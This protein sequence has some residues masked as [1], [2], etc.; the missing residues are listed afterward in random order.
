M[1]KIFLTVCL[2]LFGMA[3]MAQTDSTKFVLATFVKL[4]FSNK[5]NLVVDMGKGNGMKKISEE[6]PGTSETVKT[7]TEMLNLFVKLGYEYIGTFPGNIV[8]G[9][10]GMQ[11][12]KDETVSLF[13]KK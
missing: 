5:L 1:K 2:A 6:I 7:F 9:P 8:N 13:R 11:V 4:P 3:A 12:S 10:Y